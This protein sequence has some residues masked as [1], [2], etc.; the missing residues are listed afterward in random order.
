MIKP[1]LTAYGLCFVLAVAAHATDLQGST[2]KVRPNKDRPTVYI[3]YERSGPRVPLNDGEGER[4]IWLRLHNNTK[5]K[6]ILRVGG[7]PN[8]SYGDAVVFY[9]VERTEGSGFIPIGYRS[10]V[11]SVIK[12]KAGDS[13]L[14]S[15]PEE[16][17]G[18][19]LALKVRYNYEWELR[20]DD[21]LSANEPS[22]SV[23]FA[24]SDLPMDH[25]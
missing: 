6:L 7:V 23:T 8:P 3:T 14:F 11:A 21:S 13:I 18:K 10:H 12:L 4:G 16:H 9:E 17:L 22:H 24:S 25:G 19:G 5:W 20:K 2:A 1:F 15:L